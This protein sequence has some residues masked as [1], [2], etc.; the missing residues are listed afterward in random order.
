M[1]ISVKSKHK[2]D[3]LPHRELDNNSGVLKKL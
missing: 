3:H 1:P 2:R